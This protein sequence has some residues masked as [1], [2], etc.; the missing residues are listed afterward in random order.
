M[1]KETK[2]DTFFWLGVDAE[3]VQSM[4]EEEFEAK[5]DEARKAN[6]DYLAVRSNN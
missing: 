6:E 4:S 2:I 3:T 1:N 5:V